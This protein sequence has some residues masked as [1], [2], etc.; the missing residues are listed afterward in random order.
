VTERKRSQNP[1]DPLPLSLTS[2]G[3][4]F[5]ENALNAKS[6]TSCRRYLQVERLAEVTDLNGI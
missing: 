4:S 6:G 5:Y 2:N 1:K 3:Y